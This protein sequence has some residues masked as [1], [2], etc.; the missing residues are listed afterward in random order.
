MPTVKAPKFIITYARKTNP[1]LFFHGWDCRG[2][3]KDAVHMA[4][5]AAAMDGMAGA[6]VENTKSKTVMFFAPHIDH[7]KDS[8]FPAIWI[9]R[10]R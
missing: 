1:T 3:L 2:N 7:V 8:R 4:K 5:Q 9:R 6:Q 10:K